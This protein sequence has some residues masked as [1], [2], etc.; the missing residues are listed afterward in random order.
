MTER[1]QK[2]LGRL[3]QLGSAPSTWRGVVVVLTGLGVGLT[4]E[5]SEAIV[6]G[7][8]ILAGLIAIFAE[9]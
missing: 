7:G 2:I 8:L 1:M 4:T 6:S 5:H 3:V 9:P